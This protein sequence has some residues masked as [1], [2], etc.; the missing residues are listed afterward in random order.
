MAYRRANPRAIEANHRAVW[1]AR[2]LVD[3]QDVF[4]AGYESGIGLGRDDP[5]LLQM[6]LERVF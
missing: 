2:P 3:V 1:I 4:H 5:L 6:R